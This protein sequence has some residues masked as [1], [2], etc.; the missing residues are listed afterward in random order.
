MSDV[1]SNF[2]TRAVEWLRAGYPSG[3]PRQD[4]VVLLGLLRRKLT[5]VEVHKIA[6]DLADQSQKTSDPISTND[7]EEMI[8]SAVLQEASPTDVARVSARLAAGGW[9]LADPP[10]D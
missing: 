2:L 5:D 9:P 1:R 10:L 4:Y 8:N 7:I 6:Q 3:V